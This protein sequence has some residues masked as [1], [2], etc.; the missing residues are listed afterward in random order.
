MKK[1]ILLTVI[2][3]LGTG[4]LQAQAELADSAWTATSTEQ[5]IKAEFNSELVDGLDNFSVSYGPGNMTFTNHTDPSKSF[6]VAVKYDKTELGV[7]YERVTVQLESKNIVVENTNFSV[8]P[9]N[10]K[11]AWRR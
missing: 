8:T 4:H 1:M 10:L 3:W 5:L 9:I 11:E 6:T 2:M 7:G